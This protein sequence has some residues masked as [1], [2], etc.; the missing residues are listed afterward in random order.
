VVTA[1]GARVEV[2]LRPVE[3]QDEFLDDPV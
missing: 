3:E 2:T 1:L